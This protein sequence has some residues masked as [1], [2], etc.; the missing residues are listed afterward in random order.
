MNAGLI[1]GLVICLKK[2]KCN[3]LKEL[4]KNRQLKIIKKVNCV[5]NFLP[6]ANST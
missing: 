2:V 6:D 3:S 5:F 4:F 1:K